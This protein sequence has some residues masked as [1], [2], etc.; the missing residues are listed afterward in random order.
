VPSR[1]L[2]PSLA[3]TPGVIV[4]AVSAAGPFKERHGL[5]AYG[6]AKLAEDRRLLADSGLKKLLERHLRENWTLAKTAGM[7]TEA[8]EEQ[9]RSFGVRYSREA[10]LAQAAGQHS[11]WV[12]AD[13][14]LAS[15]AVTCRLKD[16]DFLGLAACELWKRLVPDRPS[17]EM[18][19]DAMQDGY[20]LSEAGRGA[21]ACDVWWQVWQH[22]R[23]RFTPDQRKPD[24][25]EFRG[26]QCLS[27]WFQDF[28]LEL[29]NAARRESRF[30]ALGKQ[31]CEDWLGQ[32]REA[33][34]SDLIGF[35]RARADFLLRL[36][37]REGERVLLEIVER[38]PASAWGYVALSDA[39]LHPAKGSPLPRN[40]AAARKWLE[41]GLAHVIK[42]RDA[43]EERLPDLDDS[44][45]ADP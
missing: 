23:K 10:F 25:V 37:D 3:F 27:N 33:R 7:T 45:R 15:D 18:L 34:E 5:S 16:E 32:F 36:G 28:E 9:L 17:T 11:A 42:D 21:E 29:G 22:L 12:V 30:A 43:L 26:L 40:H 1:D 6:A 39:Y 13:A 44:A 19:D 14:W 4:E 20:V 38:W 31:Y 41:Q 8:L 2:L 35:S 24:D